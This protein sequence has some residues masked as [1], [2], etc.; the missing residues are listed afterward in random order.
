MPWAPRSKFPSEI[1]SLPMP[2]SPGG[3][4]GGEPFRPILEFRLDRYLCGGDHSSFNLAGFPAIRFTEWRE[5]FHHQH[6]DVRVENGIQYGDLLRAVLL[7]RRNRDAGHRGGF[8]RQ[9]PVRRAL[10]EPGRPEQSGGL[11]LSRPIPGPA[12]Q[13]IDSSRCAPARRP[14]RRYHRTDSSSAASPFQAICTPMQNRMKAT[15]RRM[16]CAVAG[17]IARVM[18][19]A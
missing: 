17:E 19:G 11:R 2:R 9:R 16:P 15:T 8:Q 12:A 6:Q 14:P 18:R 7:F 3:M 10:G 1:D 5:D 13:K 4:A